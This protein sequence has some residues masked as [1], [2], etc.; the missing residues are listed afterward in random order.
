M[1]GWGFFLIFREMKLFE[2]SGFLI[3]SFGILISGGFGLLTDDIRLIQY[4]E[5]RES[6]G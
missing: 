3:G 4:T 1:N 5:F 2:L 6:F